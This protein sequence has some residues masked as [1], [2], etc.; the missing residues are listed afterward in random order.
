ML[1]TPNEATWPG[2]TSNPDFVNGIVALLL[3]SKSFL[4]LVDLFVRKK[5]HSTTCR[6]K[7]ESPVSTALIFVGA[8]TEGFKPLTEVL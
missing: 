5:Y 2:I 8:V 6:V 7:V 3:Q 1:G 4:N